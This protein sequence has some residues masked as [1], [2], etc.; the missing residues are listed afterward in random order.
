MSVPERAAIEILRSLLDTRSR[1]VLVGIGDDAA[2]LDQGERRLVW[3]VD[4]CVDGVHF[5]RRWLSL[6]DVGWRSFQ[7]AVSDVAAMGA[8]PLAALS[9]LTLPPELTRRHL[10]SLGRG[11]AAA[12][13]VHDCPVAGGNIATGDRLTITTTVIGEARRPV[14]RSGAIPGQAVYLIGEVG[15]AAGG[16]RLLQLSERPRTSRRA[17]AICLSAWRR[18]QAQVARGRRVGRFATSAIDL[19]DGLA[20]DCGHLAA[21][22]SVRVVIELDALTTLIHPALREVAPLLGC[23]PVELA[24]AG[25]EDYALLVSAPV[26]GCPRWMRRVGRTE[27]GSGVVLELPGGKQRSVRGGFEHR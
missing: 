20:G 15:L 8:R 6:A 10:R 3:T 19:S 7:A 17:Q 13:T 14:L 1:R 22:S 12:A 23:T 21:A 9:S 24:L 26:R 18:P 4:S 27:S 5:D 25:G 11:Q 16:L 2:V